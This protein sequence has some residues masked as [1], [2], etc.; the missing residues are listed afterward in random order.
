M[1]S[2]LSAASF[3]PHGYC[4]LWRPWLVALYVVGDLL[5][6]ASYFSIPGAIYVFVSRRPDF[7]YKWVAHLFAAFIMLCGTTHLVSVATL[8]LPAYELEAAVKI[9]TATASVTT[10]L[11]L[12]PLLPKVLA[13]PSPQALRRTSRQL[14]AEAAQRQAAESALQQINGDLRRVEERTA[15]LNR[16][17]DELEQFA[18]VASHDLQAPLRAIDNL[19][20]WLEEDLAPVL[21]NEARHHMDLLHNRVR[22]LQQ[23]LDDLLEYSRAGRLRRRELVDLR[24]LIAEVIEAVAPPAGFA[25]SVDV[26]AAPLRTAPA[27]LRQVFINLIGN[28][29]K[30][31]DRPAGRIAVTARPRGDRLEVAVSDDG[32]GIPERHRERVFEMFFTLQPRDRVEGSGMG[33][34]LVRKAVLAR[35]GTVTAAANP[36]GRGTTIRFDWPTAAVEPS[37][38]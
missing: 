36:A 11:L 17:N 18:C 22:R 15:E 21:T 33:L 26:P 13:L 28:A 32:P 31:H 24:Q 23:L 16:S 20:T 25:I 10:A 35:G 8:W 37:P 1:E 4:L 9:A 6:A 5:I 27:L 14:S 34:A 38:T 29:I 2:I 19:V 30:H 7:P 3:V 12:W